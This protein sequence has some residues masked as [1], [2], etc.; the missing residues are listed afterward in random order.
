MGL[1]GIKRMVFCALIG[2]GREISSKMATFSE[3]EA[4]CGCQSQMIGIGDNPNFLWVLP[5][6]EIASLIGL[7]LALASFAL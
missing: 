6:L 2:D 4:N 1:S 5:E 3:S 7:F